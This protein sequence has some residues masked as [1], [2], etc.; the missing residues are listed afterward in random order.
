M[1]AARQLPTPP[2]SSIPLT[3]VG[4]CFCF[5]V[6]SPPPQGFRQRWKKLSSEASP[7]P[8]LPARLWGR[9]VPG[10]EFGFLG[11]TH[12]RGILR[13]PALAGRLPAAHRPPR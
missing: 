13:P 6:A 11:T 4:A 5:G 7:L 1:G 2:P 12:A 10:E 8:R 3:H 9:E